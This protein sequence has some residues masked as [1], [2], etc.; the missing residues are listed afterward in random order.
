LD[1]PTTALDPITE[2]AIC[3]TLLKMKGGVTILVI[4]H[5]SALVEIADIRYRISDG[6]I[7]LDE[8]ETVNAEENVSH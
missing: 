6:T 1:E 7:F 3:N 2:R 4:S 5:Q 8:A